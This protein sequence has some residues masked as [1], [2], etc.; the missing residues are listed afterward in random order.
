MSILTVVVSAIYLILT[1]TGH[2]AV[3]GTHAQGERPGPMLKVFMIFLL[4]C[5]GEQ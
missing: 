4:R 1:N 3:M 2:A 5:T